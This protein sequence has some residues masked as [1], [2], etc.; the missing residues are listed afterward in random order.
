[1]QGDQFQL[2]GRFPVVS[3]ERTWT[4]ENLLLYE[5]KLWTPPTE[6]VLRI[7]MLTLPHD[8]V[9]PFGRFTPDGQ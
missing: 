2:L 5:N 4:G 6:K 8:I 7:R 3:N 1:L 9:V